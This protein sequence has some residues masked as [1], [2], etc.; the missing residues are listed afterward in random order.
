M[1]NYYTFG[2]KQKKV[3]WRVNLPIII[4][5]VCVVG[6]VYGLTSVIISQ[7]KP[8]AEPVSTITV[9]RNTP[10]ASELNLSAPLVDYN[11]NKDK[12]PLSG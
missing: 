12:F 5:I 8:K 2:R 11:P 10:S 4:T 6:I 9:T 3:Q 1:N 7:I